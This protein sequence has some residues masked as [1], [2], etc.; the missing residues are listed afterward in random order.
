VT[1]TVNVVVEDTNADAYVAVLGG[2]SCTKF[3]TA[4]ED[5]TTVVVAPVME[6]LAYV[7]SVVVLV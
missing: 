5:A 6:T 3:E 1:V 4:P 7:G 2:A